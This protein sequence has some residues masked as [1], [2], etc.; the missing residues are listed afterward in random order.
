VIRTAPGPD[1][2]FEWAYIEWWDSTRNKWRTVW[3]NF[4]KNQWE[5]DGAFRAFIIVEPNVVVYYGFKIK[6]KGDSKGT[7]RHWLVDTANKR[8]L[9][10]LTTPDLAPGGIWEEQLEPWTADKYMAVKML[11]CYYE[12]GRDYIHHETAELIVKI[13]EEEEKETT[14]TCHGVDCKKGEWVTLRATLKEK[15]TGKPI[16]GKLVKFYVDGVWKGEDT[17]DGN[18]DASI[19]T[20]CNWSP[21]THTI[22]AVFEGYENLYKYKS[23]SDSATLRV[24][25]P[26]CEVK[27]D[28]DKYYQGDTVTISYENAPTNSTL[29]IGTYP[30]RTT[31][32][33]WTVSGSGSKTYTIPD[34]A[35]TGTWSVSLYDTGCSKT[36]YITVLSK[37]Q[38]CAVETDKNTYRIGETITIS[39][40][41]APAGS[42][43]IL[44]NPDGVKKASWSVAGTSKKTYK[45]PSDTKTGVW[46]I[47]LYDT[48]CFE[49]SKITVIEECNRG[50]IISVKEVPDEGLQVVYLHPGLAGCINW[51]F[52]TD[53]EVTPDNPEAVFYDIRNDLLPVGGDKACFRVLNRDG[54]VMSET[55]EIKIPDKGCAGP[56]TMHGW[57]GC[58]YRTRITTDPAYPAPG[59]SFTLKAT[60]IINP[61]ELASED[62]EVEFFKLVDNKEVPLDKNLTNP[63]GVAV[64]S[65]TEP[66]AGRYKYFARYTGGD[67][68]AEIKTVTVREP[69]C[70]IDISQYEKMCPIFTATQGTI[71]F[72]K[73]D[74][75]RWFRDNHM[76][77]ALV[78][79]YY[80]LTPVTGRI[81]KYSRI[82]RMIIRG[83]T[84][85]SIKVIEKRWG[86]QIVC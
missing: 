23:S 42:T 27:T 3:H 70:P 46:T 52:A 61:K 71:V 55:G 24:T 53:K 58:K 26:S 45:L 51:Q 20:R 31:G 57:L 81:A 14:L 10:I 11:A 38:P 83:L 30:G 16:P 4:S 2:K 76:P 64:L 73:L 79:A 41:N 21:G 22:K 1:F 43:L 65:H 44:Y 75:L 59:K 39:Y 9:K 82:A 28:K 68:Y 66:E 40:E 35:P 86:T 78:K 49:A 32:K 19:S 17:T 34:N 56:I 72:T 62:M 13:R 47:Q 18:G 60:L 67:T 36:K 37:P 7:C 8:T 85:I 5:E 63:D 74:T 69:T 54:D 29:F 50:V 80:W 6:N 33:S 25:A 84:E 77:K 15:D 12:N 48:D